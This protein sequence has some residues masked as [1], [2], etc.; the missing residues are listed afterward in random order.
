MTDTITHHLTEP[1]LLAYA[2][3]SLPEA[4]SLAVATHVSMCDACRAALESHQ[5]VGGALLDQAEPAAVSEDALT[6]ALARI[7]AP[8]PPPARPGRRPRRRIACRRRWPAI[9]A[10][11]WRM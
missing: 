1:L 2:A 8:P 7:K 3:G 4:F 11:G 9:S 5:A 10:A 6:T